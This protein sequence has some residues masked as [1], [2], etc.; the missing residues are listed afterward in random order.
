MLHHSAT[1]EKENILRKATCLSQI[2]RGHDHFHAARADA[3]DQVF[4]KLGLRNI[5]ACGRLIH[6][7]NVWFTR[8]RAGKRQALL[9]AT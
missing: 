4:N 7:E 2:M 9:L 1:D 5:K 8:N 3:L 6:E